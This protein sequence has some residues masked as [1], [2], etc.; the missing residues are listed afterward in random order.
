MFVK[1]ISVFLENR[2][3]RLSEFSSVLAQNNIDLLAISVAD[4]TNFG[5]LRAI[6]GDYENAA[7]VLR[8]NDYT[9]NITDVL[10]VGVPDAPGGLARVLQLLQESDIVI[11]YLYSLVRR[12]GDK[13]VV[14]CRVDRPE[15]AAAL[16]EQNDI[17]MMSQADISA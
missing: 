11:E 1:Q 2:Q 13:A 17:T 9:A 7:E 3:G 6:V 10:A 14:I 15:D 8:K 5:M 4:T 16:L 12:I